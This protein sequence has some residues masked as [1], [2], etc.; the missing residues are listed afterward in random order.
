MRRKKRRTEITVETERVMLVRR[1]ETSVLARCEKCGK[2]VP[3]LLPEDAA[4]LSGVSLRMVYRRLRAG[5]MHFRE[6]PDGSL[7]ICSESALMGIPGRLSADS[8]RKPMFG[9]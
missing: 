5:E 8:E 7:M 2:T 9:R 3:M 1:R 4:I 6:M